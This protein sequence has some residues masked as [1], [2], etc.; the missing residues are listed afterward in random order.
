MNDAAIVLIKYVSKIEIEKNS[1]FPI[2]TN[3]L[4]QS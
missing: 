2:K 4:T 3:T 1:V